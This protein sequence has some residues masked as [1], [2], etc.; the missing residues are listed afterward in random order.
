MSEQSPPEFPADLSRVMTPLSADESRRLTIIYALYAASFFVG[1][2]FFAGLLFNVL[3]KA[4]FH[5]DLAR[6]H[7]RWQLRSALFALLWFIIGG[8]AILL[9]VGWILM[10]I[11]G[12]WFIYRL[13]RGWLALSD[14]Q[15]PKPGF[16]LS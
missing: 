7:A 11:V 2:T 1:I 16:G 4:E 6:I 13:V 10:G 8:M 14:Q 3:W 15:P 12:I 5:S 9:V